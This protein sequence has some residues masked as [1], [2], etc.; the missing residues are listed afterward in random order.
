MDASNQVLQIIQGTQLIQ[1][2]SMLVHNQETMQQSTAN[3]QIIAQQTTTTTTL[4]QNKVPQQ[5]LPKPAAGTALA[6]NI[7][8]QTTTTK[9]VVTQAKTSVPVQPQQ[10]QAQQFV[11][12][13]PSNVAPNHGNQQGTS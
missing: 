4:K 3:Q 5:I 9:T 7:I 11:S 12:A 10:I 13:Q 2:Q 6:Q 1:Q 8:Q